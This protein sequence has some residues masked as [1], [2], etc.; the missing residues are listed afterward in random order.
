[1]SP[2]DYFLLGYEEATDRV[3][4]TL[5][6]TADKKEADKSRKRLIHTVVLYLVVAVGVFAQFMFGAILKGEP[7]TLGNFNA[8]Q[9]LLALV[10]GAI[11]FPTVYRSAGFNRRKPHPIHWFIAFQ[12]GFFWQALLQSIAAIQ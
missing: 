9:L 6:K 3:E 12:N 4:P 10:V 7:Q 11:V 8:I 5:G 2:L 1:M